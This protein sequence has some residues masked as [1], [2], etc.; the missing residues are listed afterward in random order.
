MLNTAAAPRQKLHAV[1]LLLL[2]W[3]TTKTNRAIVS[4]DFIEDM[5]SMH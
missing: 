5:H 2:Q 3:S 4:S 1:D